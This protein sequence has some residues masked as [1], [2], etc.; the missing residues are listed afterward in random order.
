MAL[1]SC[2]AVAIGCH[3][4]PA[5][6]AG[7]RA[8]NLSAA[9]KTAAENSCHNSIGAEHSL[10]IR[11]RSPRSCI[12]NTSGRETWSVI[13]AASLWVRR[14][15]LNTA[16]TLALVVKHVQLAAI[17]GGGQVYLV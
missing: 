9:T 4:S 14:R 3:S 2:G 8:A 1:P 17:F 10:A 16:H 11:S 13:Y 12:A 7:G 15:R 6:V 5:V